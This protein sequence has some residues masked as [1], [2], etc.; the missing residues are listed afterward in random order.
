MEK[1]NWM[2]LHFDIHTL[3]PAYRFLLRMRQQS[4]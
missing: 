1:P 2:W 3:S 4:P